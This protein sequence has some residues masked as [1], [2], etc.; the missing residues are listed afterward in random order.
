LHLVIGAGE[1]LGTHVSR[2][3][4]S[5]GAAIELQVDAD[6][7]ALRDAITG[8]EVVVFC[9]QT[10][11][12]GSRVR[13]RRRPPRL[14][15][16]VVDAAR[17]ARVRRLVHVSTA[18]VFGGG[19][20]GRI[21]ERSSLDPAHA[22]EKAKLFEEEWLLETAG[23]ELDV[24]ILRPA[25]IFGS[26]DDW[27]LPRLISAAV[28]GTVWL[29][30]GGRARQTFVAAEDI[31]RACLAASDRGRPGHRYL[32]A[33]FDASWRDLL[34]SAARVAGFAAQIGSLPF[35]LAYLRAIATE[36]F[37]PRG[38][39]VWPGTFAVDVI[40]RSRLYDDSWSRR[41]L[42]WSPSVGSFEQDAA[43]MAPWLARI[44]EVERALA[45]APAVSPE[46]PAGVTSRP[47]R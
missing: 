5:D 34:V 1:F 47:G 42:T 11:A 26:G 33:G 30:G 9:A 36:T 37:A 21:N 35:D 6:D 29:P 23:D 39:T 31:G 8:I 43:A 7:E 20:A 3:L 10:V 45:E 12:P 25:R 19:E 4:A 24:V 38:G 46:P 18:D 17:R 41:E 27:I 44:P 13:F 22:Y 40:G 32:V 15:E 16:R 14:L 2:A 28:R